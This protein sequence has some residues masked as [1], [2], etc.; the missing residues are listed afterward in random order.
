MLL[1]LLLIAALSP[2]QTAPSSAAPVDML[3]FDGGSGF[4]LGY[5]ARNAASD[6]TELVIPPETVENWTTLITQQTLF[7]GAQRV[8]L[9]RFYGLWRDMMRRDCPGLTDTVEQ[10]EVEGRPAIKGMLS[11]PN[12]PETG[13][14]EN[15]SAVLVQ[16]DVHLLMIQI[17][18]RRPVGA[19]DAALIRRVNGS[20][21][22]CAP[23][24]ARCARRKDS[25]FTPT[26]VK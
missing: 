14:P 2:A 17:A 18:F 13:K 8:G 7:N 16:G 4:K 9:E 24:E 10:G 20:L 15:L 19:S 5:H 11:C 6:M 23:A 21:R 22:I 12:N 25:G 3:G 1:P 26:A